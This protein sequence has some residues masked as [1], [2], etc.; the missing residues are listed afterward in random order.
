MGCPNILDAVGYV[1]H[2]MG[3]SGIMHEA[4]G[5]SWRQERRATEGAGVQLRNKTSVAAAFGSELLKCW[6]NPGGGQWGVRRGKQKPGVTVG[7]VIVAMIAITTVRR[8][9]KSNYK[10]GHRG[11]DPAAL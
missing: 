6:K 5:D 9:N 8:D 1:F 3:E 7:G 2:Y 11:A 10:D 4:K